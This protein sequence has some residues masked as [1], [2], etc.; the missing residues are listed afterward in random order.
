MRDWLT[1][2]HSICASKKGD[3][4]EPNCTGPLGIT[5]KSAWFMAMRIR[6]AMSCAHDGDDTGPLGGAK[7]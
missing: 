5:L 3:Q 7:Q 6:E 4:R 1:A 2:I